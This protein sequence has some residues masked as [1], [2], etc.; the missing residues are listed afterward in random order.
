MRLFSSSPDTPVFLYGTLVHPDVL[1]R[2]IG[3]V[4]P[5]TIDEMSGVKITTV[6]ID[7]ESYPN[8]I[9]DSE[10][11][12]EGI[13]VAITCDELKTL[14]RYEARYQRIRRVLTSGISAWVYVLA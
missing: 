2:A 12:L 7:G 1:E 5:F 6:E 11:S 4:P 3:R 14:D 10:R 13:R 8:L 9:E